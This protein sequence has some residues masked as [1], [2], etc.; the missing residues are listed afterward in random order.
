M[1]LIIKKQIS[2]VVLVI[3]AIG[4]WVISQF[5]DERETFKQSV[6]QPFEN[7]FYLNSAK[8]INTDSSGDYLFTLQA[9][10]IEQECTD[11]AELLNV[12]ISYTPK[13]KVDWTITSAKAT[14][15][16][17]NEFLIVTGNVIAKNS[18]AQ[19]QETKI[20]S[21]LIELN[22]QKYIVKTSEHV[23]IQL[24]EHNLSAI[25]MQA[26]LDKDKL[27]LQSKINGTFL[28]PTLL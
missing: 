1:L 5:Y 27:T 16:S 25:G 7:K 15:L 24:G 20:Y 8:I 18:V 23:I 19:G 28:P 22:P 10:Y 17:K 12:K 14:K 13:S 6:V 4:T 26:T 9:D 3:F 2:L 21:E 11:S